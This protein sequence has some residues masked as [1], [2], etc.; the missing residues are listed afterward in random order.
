MG[1]AFASRLLTAGYPVVGH[2]VRPTPDLPVGLVRVV[3]LAE[4]AVQV[5][6]IVLAV[7]DT[8]QVNSVVAG[9]EGLLATF[10]DQILSRAR[11]TV[12][13]CST[14]DPDGLA[15]LALQ[16]Q[17]QGL[18]FLELPFSGTS[19]QVARGAGFGLIGGD[20][21]LINRWTSVLDVICP[22]R[23]HVGGFGDANRVKL[24]I[25][26]V[27]GLHRAALA[28]GLVFGRQ[29]GLDPAKL[30]DTLQHSAAASSVMGVKGQHMVER[31]YDPPQSRVDQSLKD[32]KLI[33]ELATQRGQPLPL[34]S[35]YIDL[36]QSCAQRG[37]AHLD[38]SIIH[39]AIARLNSQEHISC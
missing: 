32:F 3:T 36:M 4:L 14:C 15:E 28:E 29:M 21:D 11:P 18:P 10:A 1:Q 9:P 22:Q 16:A 34:V 24:A 30:L 19:L 6:L 2:D 31:C 37:E 33:T 23:E 20:Y 7:F 13:C 38:N 39:E 35:V 8:L 5:D 17:R 12:M 26:L 25:N 27:L